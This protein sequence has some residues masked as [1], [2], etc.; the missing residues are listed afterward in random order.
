M[1][2]TITASGTDLLV[3]AWLLNMPEGVFTVVLSC[4]LDRLD[5]DLGLLG[6]MLDTLSL[7]M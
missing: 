7:T 4:P 2:E 5:A 3:K 1:D 6:A